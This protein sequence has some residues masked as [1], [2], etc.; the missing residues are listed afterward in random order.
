MMDMVTQLCDGS[1]TWS[2]MSTCGRPLRIYSILHHI[3]FLTV[4]LKLTFPNFNC[5]LTVAAVKQTGFA[6]LIGKDLD[7][8][9]FSPVASEGYEQCGATYSGFAQGSLVYIHCYR[10]LVGRYVVATI[11]AT[12]STKLVVCEMEVYQDQGETS[13][14]VLRLLYG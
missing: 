12:P 9:T 4:S 3:I 13:L 6:I 5:S 14:R 11:D 8:T 7:E 1:T 10:A 2:V